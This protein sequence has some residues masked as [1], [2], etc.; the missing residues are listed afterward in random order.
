MSIEPLKLRSDTGEPY[1]LA[2]PHRPITDSRLSA[3][4][5]GVYMRCRWLGEICA[6]YGDLDW[7]IAELQMPPAE[8]RASVRRLVELGYLDTAGPVEI[9]AITAQDIAARVRDAIEATMDELTPAE[10]TAAARL[11]DLVDRRRDRAL[12]AALD[13]QIG[14]GHGLQ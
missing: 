12:E 5:V 13:A 1:L 9:E 7:L 6:P 8:T 11:A 2:V 14:R 3:A 10:R 4:D